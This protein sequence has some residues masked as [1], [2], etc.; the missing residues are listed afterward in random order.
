MTF[1]LNTAIF[2]LELNIVLLLH[3]SRQLTV[4]L[5]ARNELKLH[6]A[7]SFTPPESQNCH[8]VVPQLILTLKQKYK[9]L[10]L[11]QIYSVFPVILSS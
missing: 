5:T 4:N 3:P 1:D 11:R 8:V 6:R 9:K 2:K 7:W 10:R